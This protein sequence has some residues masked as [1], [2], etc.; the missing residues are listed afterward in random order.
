MERSNKIVKISCIGIGVN[1]IL[2]AFK[3]F[4]G[5]AC[6]SV[7]IIMD[8]VNNLSDALSSVITIIGTKLAGKAPDKKHPYGYGR[9]EHVSSI[10]VAVIVLIA[11]L[12]VFKGS[13]D[14]ILHPELAEYTP[15]SLIII[16]VAVLVKF[17]LG[18]FV[19]SEGKKNNAQS[20]VASGTEAMFDSLVSLSTLVA[21]GITILW[22]VSIEGWLGMVI[23]VFIL[24]AG[25]GILLDSLSNIIGARVESKLS[26][27][28]K[29]QIRQYAGVLGAYD[30]VLHRY[31]PEKIIGSVHIE[32]ADDMTALEIHR[33]SQEI[34]RE[35][36]QKFNII[37]TVG[38][39]ATNTTG[40]IPA[41][42][43]ETLIELIMAYP[44]I[45]ELHGFYADLEKMQVSFDIVVDFKSKR[46]PEIRD[47]LIEKMKQIYSSYVFSVI[48]DNDYSD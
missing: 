41:Q 38:I 24:K 6:G 35:I 25:I 43:K 9:I 11:G 19:K 27:E 33:L 1:L 5:L 42:M 16:A 12:T 34:T 31:G 45:L 26:V 37:L 23:S 4:V 36:K 46:A 22:H 40:E 20:L 8:A 32:V 39:Y 3:T 21:A 28:I 47:E 17:F 10:L 7:A 13:L 2:I 14:S 15:V 30:L 44:E 29:K 48:L 18:R